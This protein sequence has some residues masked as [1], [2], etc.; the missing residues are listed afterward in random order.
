LWKVNEFS[1]CLFTFFHISLLDDDDDDKDDYDVAI[2][3][4]NIVSA[5]G[6]CFRKTR[7]INYHKERKFSPRKILFMFSW[8]FPLI[9]LAKKNVF[10]VSDDSIVLCSLFSCRHSCYALIFFLSAFSWNVDSNC[11][12]VCLV[13]LLELPRRLYICCIWRGWIWHL[14]DQRI[15][16]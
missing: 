2:K 5:Y 14:W 12:V 9:Y 15:F 6:N 10:F 13:Y 8:T 3:W 11:L 7:N 16:G 1:S 4:F